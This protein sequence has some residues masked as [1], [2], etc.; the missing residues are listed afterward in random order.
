MASAPKPPPAAPARTSFD[1]KDQRRVQPGRP[2]GTPDWRDRIRTAPDFPVPAVMYAGFPK[3]GKSTYA[4]SWPNPLFLQ[5]DP[6]LA[7]VEAYGHDCIELGSMEGIVYF[8]EQLLPRIYYRELEGYDTIVLDSWS[9]LHPLTQS[10][11]EK[12]AFKDA[13]QWYGN[14]LTLNRNMVDWLTSAAK[15]KF[16]DQDAKRYNIVCTTHLEE[17]MKQVRTASG[18]ESVLDKVWPRMPG[19]FAKELCDSFNT[20]LVC[21]VEAERPAAGQPPSTD[22]PQLNYFCWSKNPNNYYRFAGDS[23]GGEGRKFQQLPP[24][25]DGTYQGLMKAWKGECGA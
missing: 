23:L 2:T 1:T 22:G 16:G 18:V 8:W 25:V 20:V 12:D 14:I 17:K 15:P 11:V 21:D 13:R 7:T 9:H 24:K 4:A 5:F 19:T 3:T 10:A 6:N